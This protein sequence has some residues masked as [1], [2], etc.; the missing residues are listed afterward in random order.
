MKKVIACLLLGMMLCGSVL[1]V[2]P[3]EA[4]TCLPPRDPRVDALLGRIIWGVVKESWG[5]WIAPE[6]RKLEAFMK[7]YEEATEE[8]TEESEGVAAG[9]IGRIIAY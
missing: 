4:L 8:A 3:A 7:A 2:R 5:A 9:I 6:G 1:T